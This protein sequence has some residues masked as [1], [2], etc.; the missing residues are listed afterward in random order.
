MVESRWNSLTRHY[1]AKVIREV[2]SNAL[3]N[4]P[5][6]EKDAAAFQTAQRVWIS[7]WIAAHGDV[8]ETW[9]EIPEARISLTNNPTGHAVLCWSTFYTDFNGVFCFI[10]FHAA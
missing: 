1:E 6:Y 4:S 7:K 3:R 10:P 8:A 5:L 2:F 9:I